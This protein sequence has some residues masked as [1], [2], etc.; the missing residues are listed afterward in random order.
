[1]P[2]LLVF[3]APFLLMVLINEYVG[4]RVGKSGYVIQEVEAIHSS[5]RLKERCTWVCHNDTNWCKQHHVKFLN[6]HFALVDQVY[7]GIIHLLKGTGAYRAANIF[8]LV[9]L[10][11]VLMCYLLV[12]SINMQ[13]E[14][15]RI[16]RKHG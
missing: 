10:I 11:P 2:Y 5:Q 9:I 16:K 8:F 7:F 6:G 12:R 14:I 1:M 15:N 13:L 4:W 3:A